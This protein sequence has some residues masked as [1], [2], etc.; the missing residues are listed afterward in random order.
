VLVARREL[1][2]VLILRSVTRRS[3]LLEAEGV[4]LDMTNLA[5][6]SPGCLFEPQPRITGIEGR[7]SFVTPTL[8]ALMR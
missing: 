2:D 4:D 7:V 3:V 8:N 5:R 6:K 1:D